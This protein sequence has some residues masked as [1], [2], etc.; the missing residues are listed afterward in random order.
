LGKVPN[1]TIDFRKIASRLGWPY[2]VFID[3]IGKGLI[4]QVRKEFDKVKMPKIIFE[5]TNIIISIDK[6]C[7]IENSLRGCISVSEVFTSSSQIFKEIWIK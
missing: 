2:S 5:A 3:I 4:D 1:Y 6:K 7:Y